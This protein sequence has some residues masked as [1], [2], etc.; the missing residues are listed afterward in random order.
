MPMLLQLLK[1]ISLP[2]EKEKLLKHLILNVTFSKKKWWGDIDDSRWT[3]RIHLEF[4]FNHCFWAR[5]IGTPAIWPPLICKGT[6]NYIEWIWKINQWQTDDDGPFWQRTLAMVCETC[7]LWKHTPPKKWT[8]LQKRDPF[9]RKNWQFSNFCRG[10]FPQVFRGGVFWTNEN[11]SRSWYDKHSIKTTVL[12]H[13]SQLSNASL[14]FVCQQYVGY[15]DTIR[16][17]ESFPLPIMSKTWLIYPIQTTTKNP[18]E[19]PRFEKKCGSEI[20]MN[21]SGTTPW[22]LH[23]KSFSK[24]WCLEDGSPKGL[25]SGAFLQLESSFQERVAINSKGCRLGWRPWPWP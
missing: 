20:F 8:C 21:Q 25:F 12:L 4:K 5:S 24:I 11:L 17:I 16:C 19:F 7:S 13:T 23:R 1:H 22:N 3:I 15:H 9:Q 14:K 6:A 2:L 18:P 10:I